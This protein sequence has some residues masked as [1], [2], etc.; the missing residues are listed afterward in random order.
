MP[1]KGDLCLRQPDMGH[2]PT[3]LARHSM[4]IDELATRP[5]AAAAIFW[6][7]THGNIRLLGT[8]SVGSIGSLRACEEG[9][10]QGPDRSPVC[11]KDQHLFTCVAQGDPLSDASTGEAVPGASSSWQNTQ[12][13]SS[14]AK[15]PA[16]ICLEP[17]VA[18]MWCGSA[19]G[20]VC[21]GASL[22]AAMLASAYSALAPTDADAVQ[23]AA[24]E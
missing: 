24:G 10:G 23:V 8:G 12:S 14:A 17:T 15:P 4:R 22:L 16:P 21:G 20:S 18:R 7:A 11:V 6:H 19:G 5:C 1:T 3:W 9:P 2:L 13:S